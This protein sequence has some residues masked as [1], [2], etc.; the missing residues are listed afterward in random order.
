M[1][2]SLTPGRWN[3]NKKVSYLGLKRLLYAD[4]PLNLTFSALNLRHNFV[5]IRHFVFSLPEHCSIRSYFLWSLSFHILANVVQVVSTVLLASF[6]ELVEL[7]LRPVCKALREEKYGCDSSLRPV[8]GIFS[9]DD[10]NENIKKQL[11]RFDKQNSSARASRFFLLRRHC[12][13]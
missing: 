8:L 7:S 3:S 6:D 1:S 12:T 10:H 13:T 9:K 11:N 4:S 2:T 5:D